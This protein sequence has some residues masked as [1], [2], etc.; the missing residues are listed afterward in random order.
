[1]RNYIHSIHFG[2]FCDLT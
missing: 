2:C 1:M